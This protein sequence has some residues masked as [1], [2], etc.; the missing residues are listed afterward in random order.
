MQCLVRKAELIAM[1]KA[2]IEEVKA[3]DKRAAR[4][5]E[6]LLKRAISSPEIAVI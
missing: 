4:K 5:L 2:R 6:N 1:L 3:E